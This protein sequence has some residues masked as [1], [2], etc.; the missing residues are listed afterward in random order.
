MTMLELAYTAYYQLCK[1][2]IHYNNKYS[3]TINNAHILINK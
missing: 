3:N 1:P 2:Y